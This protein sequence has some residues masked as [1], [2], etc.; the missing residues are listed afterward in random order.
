MVNWILE[1]EI[2]NPDDDESSYITDNFIGRRNYNSKW[3]YPIILYNYDV[4][5]LNYINKKK[6]VMRVMDTTM[7]T[8]WT[9]RRL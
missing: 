4:S 3:F 9:N 2:F 1:K 5:F 8:Q 7:E 6:V